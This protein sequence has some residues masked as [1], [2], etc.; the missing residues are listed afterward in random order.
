LGKIDQFQK[1]HVAQIL[2]GVFDEKNKPA[3]RSL[4]AEK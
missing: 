2:G 4:A 3:G 1:E